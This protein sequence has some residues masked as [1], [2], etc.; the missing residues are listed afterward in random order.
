M[1]ILD[2]T[3]GFNKA[4]AQPE[5]ILSPVFNASGYEYLTHDLALF[6]I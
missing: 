4:S 5:S 6:N 1:Q 2:S 3:A